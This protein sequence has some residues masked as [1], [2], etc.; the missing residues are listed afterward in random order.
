MYNCVAEELYET[1]WNWANKELL[2]LRPSSIDKKDPAC[3]PLLYGVPISVKECI[4]VEGCYSTG[5]L[6]CRL[7]ERCDHDCLMVQLVKN[8]GAV[9]VA[10]GN[11]PQL[12][13]LP[14]CENRIWGRTVNPYNVHRVPGG[15]SGGDA[16]L[17]SMGAVP[18]AMGSDVAGSLRIPAAFCGIVAFKPTPGR[19]SGQGCMS[20]RIHNQPAATTTLL[21][22]VIGPMARCVDDCA[23]YMKA[24][25]VPQLWET[26]R[27]LP[28]LPF[29][30]DEY[31]PRTEATTTTT[32]CV[33]KLAYFDDDGWF[34]PCATSKRAV[35]DTVQ[36]LQHAGHVVERFELPTDGWH[37]YG[38]LVAINAAEGNFKNYVDAVEGETMIDDYTLLRRAAN[39]P[40]VLRPL[41]AA[42]LL[43]ERRAHLLRQT[44]SGGLSARQVLD[45]MVQLVQ[46]RRQWATALRSY[47]AIL[48]PAMPVPALPHGVSGTLTAVCSYV[49]LPNL[50]QWPAGVV[51]V[52]TVQ[53]HEV[54]YDVSALPRN[55][56]DWIAR[57]VADQVCNHD[58]VG[59]PM[60][61]SVMAPAF[62][63]EMCLRV[64]REVERVVQF[65]TRPPPMPDTPVKQT[66][67]TFA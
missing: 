67:Q 56:Q 21:P 5:G 22:T 26:D 9:V 63:D 12:M 30:W 29:D 28:R 4:A 3:W 47:D 62:R 6:A 55:Q 45:H 36:Q 58:S 48:F 19:C 59:L 24:T 39:L 52:T 43:D 65:T 31:E 33:L 49:F 20:P 51:P 40:N 66:M 13:M 54:P 17:V 27:M 2:L 57:T 25:L 7:N 35:H 1:A 61:V 8:A 37:N 64:L 60:G 15:S 23:R 32:R 34:K 14:C 16:V 42:A 18:L 11:V 53:A 50:L 38:L 10:T 46:V 44:L 41:A